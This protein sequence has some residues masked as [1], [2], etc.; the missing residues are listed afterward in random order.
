MGGRREGRRRQAVAQVRLDEPDHPV[1]G[2]RGGV[3]QPGQARLVARGQQDEHI[4][5][6]MPAADQ[7][8]VGDGEIERRVGGLARLGAGWEIGARDQ[9]Q[10]LAVGHASSVTRPRKVSVASSDGRRLRRDGAGAQG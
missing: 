1:A 4:G 6:R 7:I 9:I 5:R 3:A 8:R 10:V 2:G